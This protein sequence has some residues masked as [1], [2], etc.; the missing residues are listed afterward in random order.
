MKHRY[1]NLYYGG[2]NISRNELKFRVTFV[3]MAS[4]IDMN[5]I[6]CGNSKMGSW[7]LT[8]LQNMF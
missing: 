3:L 8:A 7:Q 1:D 4:L 2:F 6:A 5:G